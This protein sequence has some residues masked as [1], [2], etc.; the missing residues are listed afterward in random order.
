MQL[1]GFDLIDRQ[2]RPSVTGKVA[3]RAFFLND[4]EFY[5]PYDVSA[6][7]V[8]S[9]YANTTPS[10]IVDPLTGLIKTDQAVDTILMNFGV[11][12]GVAT[13]PDRDVHDG[14]DGQTTSQNLEW[15]NPDLYDPGPIASGI[16]RVSSGDYV[17]VLDG[18]VDLSG[19]YN[20]HYGFNEGITVVNGASAVSDYIDVWTVKMSPGS[21]YQLFINTFQ[22]FNDTYISITEPLLLTTSNRLVNKHVTLSSIVDLLVTTEITV[23]NKGLS[24]S[25]KNI[26]E[27]YGIMSAQVQI[28][29]VN[30]DSTNLPARETVVG[31][32]DVTNVTSDNT[33]IYKFDTTGT[34]LTGLQ[35]GPVGTFILTAKY[36][37]IGQTIYTEPFYFVIS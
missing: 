19:G 10:S 27:D 17:A 7:T 21:E 9:K 6:C 32:T 28:Q 8:F 22:L 24:E 34:T 11:S 1:N 18:G 4:G 3:L 25:V 23:N 16:Y 37:F 14:T 12:G 36:N 20:I 35:G 15:V 33:M 29:K 2:N 5:D 30:E 31:W 13:G 26:I